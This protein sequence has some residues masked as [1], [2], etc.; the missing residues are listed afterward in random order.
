MILSTPAVARGI[1]NARADAARVGR[2]ARVRAQKFAA[3]AL[4]LLTFLPYPAIPAGNNT[5]VQLGTL[6]TLLLVAQLAFLSWRRGPYYLFLLLQA[7]LVLSAAKVAAAGQP[8]LEVA[9]KTLLTWTL[10]SLTILAAQLYLPRYSIPAMAGIAVAT[11]LHVLVGAWQQYA[12]LTGGE[13]PLQPLYINPSFLSVTENAHVIARYIQRPFGLF[14]EPSA[15]SSSLAPWVLLW[16]AEACGL[17]KFAAEP[18]RRLRLLFAVAA[19]GGLLLIISS[20]SGHAVVTV[21]AVV[22]FGAVWARHARATPRNFV[23]MVAVFGV[24]LPLAAWLTYLALG[25]RISEAAGMN[26]SWEDRAHSLLIG[27]R[28]WTGSDVPTLVFGMGIG[29]SSTAISGRTGLEAVWS[30]LLTYVYESG[31]VGGLVLAWIGAFLWRV[32]RACRFKVVF[33]VILV[34]WLVGVTVTTSYNQLLP[35]WMAFG[36]FTVWTSAFPVEAGRPPVI[37]TTEN[38]REKKAARWRIESV[39]PGGGGNEDS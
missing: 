38:V 10:A 12:F 25:D 21:A 29:L 20:R 33:G 19:V 13:L 36:L 37:R 16:I 2:G 7:P 3:F 27:L 18:S 32:W 5:A 26:E 28:L 39:Q 4:G 31:V 34:V 11:I 23:T 35:I 8:G 22:V 1:V 15:M 24:V 14:P 6:I 30:V 17:I 9:I